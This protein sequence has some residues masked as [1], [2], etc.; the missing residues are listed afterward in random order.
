MSAL[1]KAGESAGLMEKILNRLADTSE[2]GREFK[3]KVMGAMIYPIIILI[4]MVGVMVLMMVLVIPKMTALYADFDA[5]LPF[6]TKVLMAISDF[7]G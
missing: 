6:A 5:D 3:G 1:V 2:K 4:G 7:I